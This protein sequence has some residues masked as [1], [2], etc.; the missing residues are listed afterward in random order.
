MYKCFWLLA[1]VTNFEEI[2]NVINRCEIEVGPVD[3]LI[4]CA[5]YA[6]PSRMEDIPLEHVKV[7]I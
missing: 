5:G 4:N 1:D 3:I 6:Y 7:F 2:E